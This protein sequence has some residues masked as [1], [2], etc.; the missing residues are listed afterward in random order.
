MRMMSRPIFKPASG[1]GGFLPSDIGTLYQWLKADAYSGS[2]GDQV[3]TWEDSH[4]TNRDATGV[5]ATKPIYKTN[6]VNSLPI[7]RFNG[8][9]SHFDLGDFSALTAL[10][11]FI[12]IKIDTEMPAPAESG[13]WAIS[14]SGD[15]YPDTHFPYSDGT[16]YDAFGSTTRKVVG[17][18]TLSLSS[19]FRVYNVWSASGDWAANLDGSN[20]YSSATNTVGVN[21]NCTLGKSITNTGTIYRLDGD[22]AEFVLFSAKISG[23]DRS[24][25]LTYLSDKYGLGL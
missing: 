25:M 16:I 15:T 8:A 1:G 11:V 23:G 21:S 24:S 4:T 6:I 10:E 9:T 12:V 5:G 3:S 2:D 14:S 13:L 7:M 20:L 18:P 19:T 17:N 22:V